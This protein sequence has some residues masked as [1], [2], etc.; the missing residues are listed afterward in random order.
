LNLTQNIQVV[1][2]WNTLHLIRSL[3]F[4]LHDTH[5]DKIYQSVLSIFLFVETILSDSEMVLNFG[6]LTVSPKP[7]IAPGDM[8]VNFYADVLQKLPA[9]MQVSFNVYRL[10]SV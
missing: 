6:N 2:L 4:H 9:N 3:W 5:A 8:L 7:L 10:C 1:A